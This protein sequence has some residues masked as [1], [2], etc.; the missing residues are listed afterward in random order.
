M[1][2]RTRNRAGALAV[3]LAMAGALLA[4]TP[5]L[6]VEPPRTD[7]TALERGHIDAFFTALDDDGSVRLLLSDD[8]TGSHINRVPE[9]VDL[10]V[11]GAALHTYSATAFVPPELQGATIYRL[12]ANQNANL[13]WPGWDTQQLKPVYGDDVA[14][15]FDVNAEGPG[16]IWIW[17]QNED[18][19]PV[20]QLASGDFMLTPSDTIRQPFPSHTH[21]NWAFSTAGEY[22]LTV[23]ARVSGSGGT[24]TSNTAVYTFIVAPT[25]EAT[26]AQDRYSDGADIE[27]S[28][29]STPSIQGGSYEWA[30]DG[31][32]I[33]G[34]TGSALGLTADQNLDGSQVTVRL[35]G[36][37]GSE[38]AAAQ[39]VTLNVDALA[40][41]Q[42]ISISGLRH[43]YHQGGTIALAIAAEPEAAGGS[44]EWFV[45]RADQAAPVLIPGVSGAEL[46]LVAEQ[47]LDGAIVTARLL[48]AG[49]EELAAAA[50]VTIDIDDHGAAAHNVVTVSGVAHH[51][52]TGDTANLTASVAPA[53]VLTRYLWEVQ[54]AGESEWI[55]AD[56]QHGSTYS[57]AVAEELEGALVRAVLAFDTGDRYTVS[58]PVRIAVDDHHDDGHGDDHG[59]D[60]HGDDDGHGDDGGDGHGGGD[61]DAGDSGAGTGGADTSVTGAG[62]SLGAGGLAV[63][64]AGIAPLAIGGSIALLA[65][66]AGAALVS[67]R[68][69]GS[70]TDS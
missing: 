38:I 1:N 7:P 47:A 68:R 2:L 16:S 9:T 48:D 42:H 63:T 45:Q 43:H 65:L 21:T 4:P 25:L 26:G 40:A 56:G 35:I 19:E 70:A 69:R 39:A 30:I 58:E 6:A 24:A 49:G 10:V 17:Q 57:F 52:H 27:L 29:A 34:E 53:S 32:V 3:A 60:D 5:A 12:P 55:A 51:Y 23:T 67:A 22:R 44:Y 54:R 64:G 50:A 20:S 13:I 31:D 8:A 15:D 33:E 14:V 36:S 41:P 66:I 11:K 37:A 59:D 28:A 46:A 62:G 61:T 18:G